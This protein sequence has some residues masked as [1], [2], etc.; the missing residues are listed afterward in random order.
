MVHAAAN[1]KFSRRAAP[2]NSPLAPK[3]GRPC[4]GKAKKDF[5]TMKMKDWVETRMTVDPYVTP[6]DNKFGDPSFWSRQQADIYSDV[7]EKKSNEVVEHKFVDFNYLQENECNFANVK[8]FC[9]RLGLD[10]IM[11]FVQDYNVDVVKQFY[12]TVF[13][14]NDNIKTLKWMTGNDMFSA[15]FSDFA[16]AMDYEEQ[17]DAGDSLQCYGAGLPP[18]KTCLRI[19]YQKGYKKVATLSG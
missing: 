13:F 1:V 3:R 12:A 9:E 10:K 5:L 14:V 2:N 15:P 19:L 17:F 18:S 6:R 8:V 16:K 7:I 4:K 11:K